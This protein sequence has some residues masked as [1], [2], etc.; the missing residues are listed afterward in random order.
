M[1]S[2]PLTAE[3]LHWIVCPVCRKA[4]QLE[5]ASIRCQGCGRR[6]PIIDGIPVLLAESALT[7]NPD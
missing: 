1:S 2:Q 6:Y 4:L 7:D 3:D 5:T